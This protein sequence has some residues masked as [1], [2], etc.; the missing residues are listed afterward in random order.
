M[1]RPP[2]YQMSRSGK[3]E[4]SIKPVRSSIGCRALKAKNGLVD[5]VVMFLFARA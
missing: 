5:Q 2:T 1:A 3:V 4:V